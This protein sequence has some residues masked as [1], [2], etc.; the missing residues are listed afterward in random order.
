[1]LQTI[2]PT[3]V[4]DTMISRSTDTLLF[5]LVSLDHHVDIADNITLHALM[6][7]PLVLRSS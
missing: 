2:D 6:E 1:M 7:R 3:A 4:H 5:K